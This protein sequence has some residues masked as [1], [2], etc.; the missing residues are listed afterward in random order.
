MCADGNDPG[1]EEKVSDAGESG[2]GLALAP[3]KDSS[4]SEEARRVLGLTRRS[5]GRRCPPPRPLCSQG[6]GKQGQQLKR[7]EEVSEV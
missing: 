5:R 3:S 4:Q 1:E 7:R 6:M 2:M